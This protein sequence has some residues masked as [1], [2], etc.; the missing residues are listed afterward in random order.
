VKR[1]ILQTLT[2]IFAALAVCVFVYPDDV[3]EG[4]SSGRS[5][6]VLAP[7]QIPAPSK[8]ATALPL[9]SVAVNPTAINKRP[10][11]LDSEV[12]TTSLAL[13]AVSTCVLLC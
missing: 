5:E 11:S 4:D 6:M 9:Q 10:F 12:H 3:F 8:R 13:R 2:V 7:T 1:K